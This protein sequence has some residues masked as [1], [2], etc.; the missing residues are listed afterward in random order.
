MI[1]FYFDNVLYFDMFC[2]KKIFRFLSSLMCFSRSQCQNGDRKLKMKTS[3]TDKNLSLS[4]VRHGKKSQNIVFEEH[5][6][7][8]KKKNK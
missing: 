6:K 4:Y 7:L 2:N 3:D 8:Q 5:I 1:T